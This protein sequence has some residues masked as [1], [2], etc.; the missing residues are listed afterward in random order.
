VWQGGAEMSP[1][2]IR[3]S[4]VALPGT[5][6][7]FCILRLPCHPIAKSRYNLNQNSVLNGRTHWTGGEG[8]VGV[9]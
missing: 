6:A 5:P 4:P 8:P 2:S 1:H 3:T 9:G 7:S